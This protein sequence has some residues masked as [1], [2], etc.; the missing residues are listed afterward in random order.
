MNAT[1]L[2]TILGLVITAI[3][4]IVYPLYLNRNKA[5]ADTA[6]QESV[7]SREVAKM[8]K[9]ER[10]R[11]QLRLDTMQAGYEQRMVALRQEN[12]RALTAAKAAWQVQ[13]ENDQN[14]IAELRDELQNLYRQLYRSPPPGS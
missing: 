7:D 13:H 11:L 2:T 1:V 9:E 4:T 10:D 8:F 6:E 3:G 5:K 14:Q 12:E